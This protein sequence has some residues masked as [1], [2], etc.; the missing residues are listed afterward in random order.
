MVVVRA[1]GDIGSISPSVADGILMGKIH[2][3]EAIA[4]L[5]HVTSLTRVW[6]GLCH[7]ARVIVSGSCRVEAI[8]VARFA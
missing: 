6:M 8:I 7:P 1:A 4:V 3:F 5:Y 2:K